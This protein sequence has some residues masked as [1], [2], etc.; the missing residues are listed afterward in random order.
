M[1]LK[2][3]NARIGDGIFKKIRTI[4]EDR[5]QTTLCVAGSIRSTMNIAVLSS[6]SPFYRQLVIREIEP[7]KIEHVRQLLRQNFEIS[8]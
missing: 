7:L 5:E 1:E 2:V 8:E 6:S 3:G 4:F